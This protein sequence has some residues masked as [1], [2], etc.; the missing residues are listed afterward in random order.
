MARQ[1]EDSHRRR[2]PPNCRH[3]KGRSGWN[4]IRLHSD[5]LISLN[6]PEA[7]VENLSVNAPI[8]TQTTPKSN[9]FSPKNDIEALMEKMQQLSITYANLSA[10]FLSQTTKP[11][12]YHRGKSAK[13]FA[14][15][16]CGEPGHYSNECQSRTKDCRKPPDSG[17]KGWITW[18]ASITQVRTTISAKPTWIL[19][20]DRMEKSPQVLTRRNGSK[21]GPVPG[22]NWTKKR[23]KKS[24]YLPLY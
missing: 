15:Y 12:K 22:T 4:R 10:A 19:A 17:L 14:C 24:T 5:E 13:N 8:R 23:K 1:Q 2:T 11:K 9:V 6:I 21:N 7:I 16:K 18:T 20:P 3:R